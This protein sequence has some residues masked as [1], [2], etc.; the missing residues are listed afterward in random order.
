MLNPNRYQKN[1]TSNHNEIPLPIL[2]W[3]KLQRFVMPLVGVNVKQHEYSSPTDNAKWHKKWYRHI[4][5]KRKKY[6]FY[7]KMNISLTYDAATHS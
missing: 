4:C 1:L 3:L 5:K 7:V 6:P 2:E